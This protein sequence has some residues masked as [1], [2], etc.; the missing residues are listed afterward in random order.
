MSKAK[1]RL[2]EQRWGEA[3]LEGGQRPSGDSAEAEQSPGDKLLLSAQAV[4]IGKLKTLA[5]W[6][7]ERI[8]C[9]GQ[10]SCRREMCWNDIFHGDHVTQFT[11]NTGV[12]EPVFAHKRCADAVLKQLGGQKELPIKFP[13]ELVL[14]DSVANILGRD[15]SRT[16]EGFSGNSLSEIPLGRDEYVA[17]ITAEVLNR[18]RRLK[19]EL[20]GLEQAED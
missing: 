20:P 6:K 16:V 4:T 9:K 12:S 5:R 11:D 10:K 14:G 3:G 2:L 8:I 17:Y 13:H 7:I 19:H 18:L 1:R 15:E